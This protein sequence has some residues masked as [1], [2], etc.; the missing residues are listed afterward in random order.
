MQYHVFVSYSHNDIEFAK[1]L[2][3]ELNRR[4]VKVWIDLEGINPGKKWRDE[5]RT[6]LDNSE[7]LVLLISSASMRSTQ[8]EEE[9]Q[10]FLRE[11]KP[12]IPLLIQLTD[13]PEQ[14]ASIQYIDFTQR[15]RFDRQFETLIAELIRIGLVD[16]SART[17]PKSAWQHYRAGK[18]AMEDSRL[19]LKND[20]EEGGGWWAEVAVESFTR[21]IDLNPEFVAAYKERAFARIIATRDTQGAIDDLTEV[22]SLEPHEHYDSYLERGRY[23]EEL[24]EVEAARADYLLVANTGNTYAKEAER[25]LRYL[26]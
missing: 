1:R 12:I 25:R 13:I 5:I 6:G 26:R 18:S 20:S 22:I 9:W 21:A 24:H 16:Q 4:T 11:E 17:P 3:R 7:L 19:A 10:H 2:V 23:F 14:I 15:A 8:V